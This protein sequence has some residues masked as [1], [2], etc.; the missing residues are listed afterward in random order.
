M[1][2]SARFSRT[3]NC[4]PKLS[5]SLVEM[6]GTV[7]G[8]SGASLRQIEEA[9]CVGEAA[10]GLVKTEL[11]LDEAPSALEAPVLRIRRT[12]LRHM[13]AAFGGRDVVPPAPGFASVVIPTARGVNGIPTPA[14]LEGGLGYRQRR[15]IADAVRGIVVVGWPWVWNLYP[16]Y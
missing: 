8:H 4:A 12:L 14:S 16:C 10:P 5:N 13:G 1:V 2:C 15:C 9:L 6:V 11:G 7:L 3:L